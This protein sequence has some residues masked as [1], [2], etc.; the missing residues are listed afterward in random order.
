[1]VE[2]AMTRRISL[3]VASIAIVACF[4]CTDVLQLRLARRNL[5]TVP[6]VTAAVNG[7]AGV[8]DDPHMVY[9]GDWV[10]VSVCHLDELV[11]KSEAAQQPITLFIE[12]LDSGN[13][14]C[15]ID[16]E[17]GTLTFILDRNAKNKELWRQFLY[18]PLFDPYST[19]RVSVG[20]R[21]DRPL[22][23]AEGA[24]LALRLKKLYVDTWTWL[25]LAL[26]MAVAVLLFVAA[27]RSDMLR[28]GPS[29]GEMRQP[30]SLARSQMA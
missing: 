15:G 16:L 20:V 10:L 29:L 1:M 23:R 21:G 5:K 9:L 12:G 14:P 28:E 19:I 7:V 4:G 30:Y 3:L 2:S 17:Q 27:R 13:E 24:N 11:K 6:C 22:P 18:D 26:L 25:W 8:N